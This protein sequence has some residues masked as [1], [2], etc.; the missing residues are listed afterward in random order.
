M[1]YQEEIHEKRHDLTWKQFYIDYKY[2]QSLKLVPICGP[3][4]PNYK[5]KWCIP[6]WDLF[7]YVKLFF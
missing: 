1:S 6:N 2:S 3:S 4:G 5:Y 7:G